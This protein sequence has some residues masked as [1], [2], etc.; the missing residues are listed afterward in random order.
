ML[1]GRCAPAH[2]P[3]LF[4]L[5]KMSNIGRK[6]TDFYC[7]GYFGRDYDLNGAEIIGEGEEYLV[8]R[9]ENGIVC[10]CNFQSW[11][12]NRHEDGS[13]AGGISNLRSMDSKERQELIDSW[14]A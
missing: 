8:I 5:N 2:L 14:C 3:M 1:S 10:F 11:Y 6:I 4:I 9:K 13:L 7:N 12:W